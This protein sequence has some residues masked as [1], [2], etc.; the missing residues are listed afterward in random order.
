MPAKIIL[1]NIR[2]I[3]L[4]F[5]SMDIK[6]QNEVDDVKKGLTAILRSRG[7]EL[8]DYQTF[9]LGKIINARDK[10]KQR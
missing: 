8:C 3:A 6:V 5:V 1:P 7:C 10:G 4:A 9:L 2:K